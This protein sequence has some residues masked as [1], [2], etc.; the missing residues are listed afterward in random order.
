MNK[1]IIACCIV[2]SFASDC[3]RKDT[4]CN[5]NSH[6]VVAFK[7]NSN[8]T[9]YYK[10]YWQ[11]PDTAIGEYNPLNGNN[12]IH[13]NQSFNIGAGRGDYCWEDL[14]K[15]GRKE[16]IHIF[17]ADS[18][19]VIPWENVRQTGRGLLERRLI[20]LQYLKDNNFQI[21]YQ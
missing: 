8:L 2:L 21:I 10:F 7:N 6:T 19:E 16:Y 9:V 18:L 13:P 15:D 11:Y 4:V 14:L 5:D 3:A 20:D 1:I 12:P 17:D